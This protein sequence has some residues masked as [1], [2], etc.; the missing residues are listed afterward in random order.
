MSQGEHVSLGGRDTRPDNHAG[1]RAFVTF[2]LLAGVLM[3]CAFLVWFAQP[4][5]AHSVLP[6]PEAVI[7]ACGTISS[8]TIWTTGNVYSATNCFVTVAAG[9]TLT[10]QPGVIV[11]FGG[12]CP[13]CGANSVALRVDGTLVASGTSAQPVVFTSFADDAHGGDTNN[14]GASSGAAGDWYGLVFNSGSQGQLSNA[15]IAYAGSGTFNA[16]TDMGYGRAQVDVRGGDLQ[17]T[18]STVTTG[19][20]KGI[21]LEGAGITPVIQ[22]V[23]VANNQMA[24][25]K[26]YAIYQ[27]T[28][29][30]QPTYANLALSGNNV[31]QVIISMDSAM[32]QDATLGGAE[33]GFR[34]GYTLCDLAVPSG[35]TLTVAP[36]TLLDFLPSYG[37]AVE[38]GGALVAEGTATQP[39]T[40]TSKLAAA[41]TPDQHWLG[42]WA[43]AGS[44]VSL[45]RCDIS[46]S[47]D[48]NYGKGGLQIDTVNA[49]V[50]NC[51]IH[52]N[53]D[54]GLYLSGSSGNALSPTLQNLDISDNGTYGVYL[55]T[56]GSTLAP[57]FEGGFIR[58]NGRAGV[59]SAVW[60]ASLV[61]PTFRDIAISNNGS[62]GSG[63]DQA[64]IRF[65]H[66]AI[67]PIFENVT[68][69]G[70]TGAAI[71]WNCD[72]SISASN[73][74]ATGNGTNALVLPGCTVTS[75]RKWS[76]AQA[77]LPV[78]AT[79]NIVI[80][81]GGLLTL[82]PGSTLRFEAGVPLEVYGALYALGTADRPITFTHITSM[83][84]NWRGIYTN[85]GALILR[86]LDL[87]Y[88]GTGSYPAFLI[89][90]TNS[91]VLVQNSKIHNSATDGVNAMV[92]TPYLHYNEIYDN[93]VTGVK[94]TY[95]DTLVDARYNY[96]GDPTGPSHATLNPSGK[97]DAVGDY[98]LFDP[99][100]TAPPEDNQ[101]TS[102]ML[103]TTGAP[104][105]IS[106]GQ[107]V[108]YAIQYL[109]LMTTTVQN[110]V[111]MIQ[112]PAAS[113]YIDSTGGGIYWPERHQVF[114]K[115]GNLA[116]NA[117]GFVSVRVRFQW[118]LPRNYKDG[119]LTLLAGDNY[120]ED[121]LN[122]AE[123]RA[124]QPVTVT[125]Q[126][127]VT[128]AAFDT[129]VN[130][131]P[132]LKTLYDQSI[133]RGYVF[134]EAGQVNYSDGTSIT[135]GMYRTSDRR[136]VRQLTLYKGQAMA[137]TSGE[138]LYILQ[139]T[140]GGMTTT[141][142]SMQ[143]AYWGNWVPES[144]DARPGI[145]KAAA[146][147][148]CTEA[149]CKVNCIGKKVTIGR[150]AGG[151]ADTFMWTIATGGTGG[152]F[153]A[154]YEAYGLIKDV[155]E[156]NSQC[157]QD[158][159]SNCCTAGQV[160]WSPPGWI[161][162]IIETGCTKEE[163]NATTG[164]YGAP[165]T[166]FC[167][168]GQRCK[169]G[170]N[171]EGGCKNCSESSNR[172]VVYDEI[173]ISPCAPSA[174]G[175]PSCSDLELLRAKDPNAIAGPEGDLLPGQWVTY[176][177]SFENVGEGRAYGVYVINQL[178]AVF[179]AA[180]LDLKG[181]GTYMSDSREILWIVGELGPKGDADSKGSKTYTM[182]LKTGLATGT[183]VNNQAVVYFPS[184]P[185]ET[186][187]NT[188]V[189]LVG[190]VAAI[191]QTLTTNYE[192]PLNIT[193]TGRK[194]GPSALTFTIVDRPLGTLTG[195]PPNL[196][197]TPPDN[198]TGVDFFTFRASSGA[199][200]SR[201]AQVLIDVTSTG[202]TVKPQVLWVTPANA[203]K[204]IS[205]S[206]TPILTDKA[207]PIYG[208]VIL[209]GFSEAIQESS[210]T[211]Q[212]VQL[213]SPSGQVSATVVFDGLLNQVTLLPRQ[214]LQSGVTYTVSLSTGIQDLAGNGLAATYQWSFET[215]RP[216]QR[217]LYLPT[218]LKKK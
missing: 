159:N 194:A 94:R 99:W 212:T 190:Q 115:L 173:T 42:L 203:A 218:V 186:P 145:S 177:V 85:N 125:G 71:L 155:W 208:P 143:R 23:Q 107:T 69:S 9:A 152:W 39:I 4:T 213:T 8:S 26:G 35:T 167:A 97:G 82:E 146:P 17:L 205:V 133:A 73:I 179:D 36:G 21:Y 172:T 117:E 141:L 158:K 140:T 156:C 149:M 165:G 27:A 134:L 33:F 180:T 68:F 126:V 28:I 201:Q 70:N 139:D 91:Y 89:A 62:A 5:A 209:A 202:D 57:V 166:I 184:V 101:V 119:S 210:V 168:Y 106:S 30:M 150:I 86:H 63:S 131:N 109:N 40:F 217:Y 47:F 56:Q 12:T 34:C 200:T 197:Y 189:N 183:V 3:A 11:K 60:D 24:D 67:S 81:A 79:W 7:N 214:A 15:Y 95:G 19:L 92:D 32:T 78:H 191:P 193:L 102:E 55:Y 135:G 44:T 161:G 103:V 64:G 116:P 46:Y 1:R 111:L 118:G 121:Q 174:P 192:T 20:Q 16:G 75:G 22:N 154:A 163:C 98:V 195:T 25:G 153:G 178:P 187:T 31:D 162:N 80:D 83:Q 196:V 61:N 160:R 170:Y 65:E 151:V 124:Y 66:A 169:A 18:N 132:N 52:H 207:G 137:A 51:H 176:T 144:A 157:N 59:Y 108:D 48:S 110:P 90:G 198:F 138:G 54:A 37:I 74:T 14:N 114:W 211:T 206:G 164:G 6:R 77:G 175:E 29:S 100:L 182:R 76:L 72:G 188:W 105:I 84:E 41:G 13:G 147:T 104:R 96:W 171:D 112:L 136:W 142:H 120:N 215:A 88:G 181:S 49:Q 50:R 87:A 204:S 93:A 216:A 123:Y 199:T 53:R 130:A 127:A 10:I 43:K 185:E 113:E 2:A 38:S 129:L 122:V 45:D 148:V 58:R 128:K